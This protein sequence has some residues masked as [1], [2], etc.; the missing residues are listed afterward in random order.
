MI[1]P[2]H[3]IPD[4]C[5]AC[6]KCIRECPV[7]AVRIVNEKAAVVACRC[8][9]CG[10]CVQA[11][12]TGAQV[13]RD[14]MARARVT[15]ACNPGRTYLSLAPAYA[16][17]F[18]DMSEDE[19]L[20]GLLRL[21]FAGV[22][23][24][25]LGA[26]M[27]TAATERF[28][29]EA[30]DGVYLSSACPAAVD[31]VRKYA[32][33]LVSHITPVV[34]P[35]IAHARLL[36]E[37]YGNDIKI[38]FAGPCI[39]KKGEAD[40]Y[41]DTV[42]AVLTFDELRAMMAEAAA[43]TP[44]RSAGEH[45]FVPCRAGIGALYPLEGGM[46]AGF[47]DDSEA[48]E[49]MAFSGLDTIR[50]VLSD[51]DLDRHE[52]KVF[53]ELLACRGGCIGAPSQQRRVSLLG[54]RRAVA[55]G[56]RTDGPRREYPPVD[57]GVN[58]VSDPQTRSSDYSEEKVADALAAIGRKRPEDEFDCGAC[59]YASCR[60]F[61]AALVE[62]Y[63]DGSLCA[64]H[65]RRMA[66]DRAADLLHK[67]PSGAVI[68]DSDLKVVDMNRAFAAALGENTLSVYDICPG[69]AG[70]DIKNFCSFENLFRTV[71]ATGEELRERKVGERGRSWLLSV[72]NIQ[73]G[74]QVFG[75]LQD[76]HETAVRKDWILDKTREVIRNHM[77][78]VQEVA[79]LLGEN[80][81]YTDSTLRSI[82]DA[83][84]N[85]EEEEPK[86]E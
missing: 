14:G 8:V 63:V 74:R 73:A 60:D 41:G 28:L 38:I 13:V 1:A 19:L 83:F 75:V 31:Y 16:G 35:M 86:G 2:V 11:C 48:V 15:L 45:S 36:R 29:A 70:A 10:H 42:D 56:C 68:I 61:A 33:H 64:V 59:G 39:A 55:L 27:V 85:V 22:S 12:P 84:G 54:R 44:E 76:L 4:K 7:N 62:G 25:A 49:R 40:T 34:S 37:H 18:A 17:E 77:A 24:A 21:G 67:I 51:P 53:L 3:T 80:A 23:E 46:I 9:G 78:T 65:M 43:G 26:E 32:P 6:Y 69:M 81:A 79:G 66:H 47:G 82:V 58:F 52:G 5:V 20:D 57:L 30:S 72:F 50:E 71:L